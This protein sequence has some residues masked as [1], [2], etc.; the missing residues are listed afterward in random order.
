MQV[1]ALNSKHTTFAEFTH[2]LILPQTCE[3]IEE[4]SQGEWALCEAKAGQSTY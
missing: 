1:T 4:H 2:L 3:T